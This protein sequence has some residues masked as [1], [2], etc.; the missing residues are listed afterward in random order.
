MFNKKPKQNK[1]LKVYAIT[2]GPGGGIICLNDTKEAA[3]RALDSSF[4]F[5]VELTVTR[6]FTRERELV[7]IETEL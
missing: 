3:I 7:E 6:V 1:G 5:L 4:P 2:S